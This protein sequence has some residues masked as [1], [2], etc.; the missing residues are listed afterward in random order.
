MRRGEKA[1]EY[2][3]DIV[4]VCAASFLL[5]FM[6]LS[7]RQYVLGN[8]NRMDLGMAICRPTALL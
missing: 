2:V 7:V 6:Y 1:C 3:K 5:I 4:C 8:A